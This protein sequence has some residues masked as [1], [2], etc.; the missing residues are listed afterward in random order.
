MAQ[1]TRT[2]VAGGVKY[3][4]GTPET[5]ELRELIND[6]HWAEVDPA[7]AAAAARNSAQTD[8]EIIELR[9]LAAAELAGRDARIAEL[10]AQVD[11]L[12]AELE[13][14]G[15]VPNVEP[16]PEPVDYLSQTGKALKDEIDRRNFDRDPDEEAYIRVEAP[17][18][19]PELAAALAADDVRAA[20]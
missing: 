9:E 17:G 15:T 5:P 8:T 12:A 19:K 1:L 14:A 16:D 6:K 18:N 7:S 13:H 20:G 3:P 10:E 4:A 11:R 2:V